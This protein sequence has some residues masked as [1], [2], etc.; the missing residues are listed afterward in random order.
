MGSGPS[1]TQTVGKLHQGS[2]PWAMGGTGSQAVGAH[3]HAQIG[4]VGT[5]QCISW[6]WGSLGS[7]RMAGDSS[8]VQHFIQEAADWRRAGSLMAPESFLDG[9]EPVSTMN[10]CTQVH[11]PGWEHKFW[12]EVRRPC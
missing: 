11:N 7:S 5:L 6:S 12:D 10:V 4:S 8:H 2:Q 3:G 1:G 9:A